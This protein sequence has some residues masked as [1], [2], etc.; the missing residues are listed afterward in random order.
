MVI[1]LLK[2]WDGNVT[3]IFGRPRHPQS[4]GLVEQANGT[5][6]RMLN[7]M[8]AQFATTNWVKLLPKVMF[9]LNTQKA[10]CNYY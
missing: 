1:E 9:N 8:M 4:N 3:H 6:Q 7:S 10:S 5:V 2:S